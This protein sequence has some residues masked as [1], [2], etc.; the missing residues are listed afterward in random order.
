MTE[1]FLC[2]YKNH[3]YLKFKNIMPIPDISSK[4]YSYFVFFF[5]LNESKNYDNLEIF[6]R[7]NAI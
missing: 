6:S 5:S 3:F 1:N 2:N 7:K 4:Q